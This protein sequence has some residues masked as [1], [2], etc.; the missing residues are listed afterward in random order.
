MKKKIIV[1]LMFF[2]LC[3]TTGCV[4]QSKYNNLDKEYDGLLDRKNELAV[5]YNNLLDEKKQ[6]KTDYE[7][8]LSEYENLITLYENATGEEYSP[9]VDEETENIEEIETDTIEEDTEKYSDEILFNDIEWGTNYT[10][11]DSVLS[12]LSLINISG[13]DYKTMSVDDIILGDYKGIDFEYDDINIIAS[14]LNGET[15]VA[16]YTTREVQLHFAY[17]P[18]DGVLDKTEENSSLYGAQYFFDTQNLQEMSQDLTNK[19]SS[20]YGESDDVKTD[21][22]MWGNEYTYTYWYGQND[23]VVVLKTVDTTNDTSGMY[24]DEIIIS[25]VWLKGD[26]LLQN[27]SDILKQEAIDNE[28]SVYGNESTDGL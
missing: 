5:S 4:S 23:T 3:S 20:T 27:A 1:A 16:G 26:E 17:I 10:N 22:D 11:V 8:L 12:S 9:Q 6:L 19:L 18:V 25:Y 14:A 21:V 15:D 2:S 7:N 24:E 28:E 13:E